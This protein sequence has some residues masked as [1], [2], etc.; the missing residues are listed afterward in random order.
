MILV[1]SSVWINYFNGKITWQTEMLDQM[2]QQI[3]V[4][5]G[6]LILTEVLQGFR[7]DHE[8]KKAK[9]V[10]SILPCKQL[11]GY[12][13]AIQSAENYRTLRK[14][15]IT[16][17]KTIDIIIGTFCIVEN[18]PLLH[19]DRDFDPLTEHLSLKTIS[20]TIM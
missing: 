15:G 17:R 12:D 9:E 5:T 1:D 8:Y 7:K 20:Q 13:I 10:L 4:C 11:G 6:D 18:I 16:V 2:L 14:K 19:D 3:P